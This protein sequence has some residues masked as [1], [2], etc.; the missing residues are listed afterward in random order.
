MA[1]VFLRRM[2]GMS[3]EDGSHHVE[4]FGGQDIGWFGSFCLVCNN[5]VRGTPQG[6]FTAYPTPLLTSLTPPKPPLHTLT[7]LA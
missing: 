3:T 7:M 6:I 2:L 1:A 4:G 5:I